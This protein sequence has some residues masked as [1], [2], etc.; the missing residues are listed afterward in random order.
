MTARCDL[1]DLIVAQCAER[2]C[3]HPAS[4]HGEDGCLHGWGDPSRPEGGCPCL[5]PGWAD[6]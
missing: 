1:T 2:C 6:R 5:S 3:P 4:D